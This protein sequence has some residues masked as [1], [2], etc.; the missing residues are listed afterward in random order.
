MQ[1]YAAHPAPHLGEAK[2]LPFGREL[3]GDVWCGVGN[4]LSRQNYQNMHPPLPT[5]VFQKKPLFTQ[6]VLPNMR[7]L[8]A[9]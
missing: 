1:L 6:L 4:D 3:S 8:P 2:L 5:P 9:C 7:P